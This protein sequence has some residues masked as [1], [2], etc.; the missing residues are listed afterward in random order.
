MA[1]NIT[2]IDSSICGG[3]SHVMRPW[4]SRSILAG[5]LPRETRVSIGSRSGSME[6]FVTW[7]AL[8]SILSQ[9]TG[10]GL[11]LPMEDSSTPPLEA[12]L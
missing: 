3:R 8:R 4:A 7:E 10:S 1:E 11:G 5:F 6:G 9:Y 12:C 2:G